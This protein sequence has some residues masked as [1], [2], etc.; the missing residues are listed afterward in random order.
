MSVFSN[1]LAFFH[2]SKGFTALDFTTSML[3]RLTS[4]A[5]CLLLA[6]Y[7]ISCRHLV[8]CLHKRLTNCRKHRD[9]LFSYLHVNP[10]K[11]LLK[12][13]LW[14]VNNIVVY[15]VHCCWFCC[16]SIVDGDIACMKLEVISSVL[17]T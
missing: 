3:Y 10:L 7:I 15:I 8:A 9:T 6:K 1:F 16:S 5:L 17:A 2:F 14:Q 12:S 11:Q 13:V 4:I